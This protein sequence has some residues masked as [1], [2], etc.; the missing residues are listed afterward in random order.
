MNAPTPRRGRFSRRAAIRAGAGAAFGLVAMPARPRSAGAAPPPTAPLAD[1]SSGSMG[2]LDD[3][4]RELDAKITA[5]MDAYGIPGV[6]LGLLAG[7][8]EYVKGYGTTNVDY[9][10]PVDGDTVFRIQST[11]KTF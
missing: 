10:V 1:S 9:P 7:D 8:L 11:T 3:R 2:S 6:A 5:A 4:I